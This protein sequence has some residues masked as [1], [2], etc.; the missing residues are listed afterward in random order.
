MSTI[1]SV[2]SVSVSSTVSE[3]STATESSTTS[4]PSIPEISETSI[5]SE[6]SEAST[7]FES[8]TSSETSSETT[9]VVAPSSIPV[10]SSSSTYSRSSTSAAGSSAP[11]SASEPSSF[12]SS[13]SPSSSIPVSISALTS[14]SV[15]GTTLSEKSFISAT[16][17]VVSIVGLSETL[18]S[19]AESEALTE[20]S[21]SFSAASISAEPSISQPIVTFISINS[22][23]SD[24]PTP[25]TAVSQDTLY[26][27]SSTWTASESASSFVV[28]R[29]SSI[30]SESETTPPLSAESSR[31]LSAISGISVSQNTVS[32]H[33][34]GTS[35]LVESTPVSGFTISGTKARESS[36]GTS[37]VSSLSRSSFLLTSVSGTTFTSGGPSSPTSEPTNSDK[38]PHVAQT[39]ETSIGTATSGPG[40]S[41]ASP[42]PT[43]KASD[44][45]TSVTWP[46]WKL[47]ESL[48]GNFAPLVVARG[49]M[50]MTGAF[51]NQA[52]THDPVR[53]LTGGGISGSAL[54]GP[55]IGASHIGLVTA[56][57]G[58]IFVAGGTFIDTNYCND[59]A[60]PNSINPCPPKVSGNPWVLD[61]I[62][63]TLV[64]QAGVVAYT[65]SKWFQKP[66]RLSADPTTIAGVAA[67]MG[68]PEIER[69]FAAFSGEMS[70]WELQLAL[71]GQQFKLG[72]FETD[73]GVTKYGI[74][75]VPLTEQK[76]GGVFGGIKESFQHLQDRISFFFGD[77]KLNRLVLDVAFGL[78]LLTLLGLTL[79][80][81]A[82]VDRPQTVFLATATG[83]GVGMKIF[84]AFLGVIISSN[85]GRLFEDTQTFTPYFP[86]RDGEARPNPTILL[87]RHTSPICAFI[88]LLRNR[89]LAAASVAFTGLISEFLII[90][91]AGLPYRPGQ[92]RTEFLFCGVAS[93]VILSV[94]LAQLVLVVIWRRSL[95]HLPR[96]PDTIAA[97][98][99]YVA[100][101]SMARD[102]YGLEEMSTKER[103]RAI[104]EMR[105]VYAYGWR[106]EP[107]GGIRWIVDEVPDAEKKSFLESS[108]VG[109]SGIDTS[110]HGYYRPNVI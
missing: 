106:Q 49:L 43:P 6:G 10:H 22:A 89:H 1:A 5:V 78:L 70:K 88:P 19:S 62:I 68:H 100:G 80:A 28:V 63:T 107:E 75:P 86:L 34:T 74:M 3:T 16:T 51:Y 54:A 36:A 94:M 52:L 29:F 66:G 101:T 31:S 108:R 37:A 65:M 11:L 60:N 87:N 15:S 72:T 13:V 44:P 85:W 24:R 96:R 8:L 77:W 32:I 103:N 76:K 50:L 64:I 47:T 30:L 25:Q 98:M 84:F 95:P 20:Y 97:V 61:I 9:T 2:S 93:A 67:V 46:Y 53:K 82:H 45:L 56:Q 109:L 14:T 17:S 48:T 91:L 92:L 81:I 83:S 7:T 33:S 26:S 12:T 55:H 90:T 27:L 69:Q 39:A 59:P 18:S 40:G 104:C 4:E 110:Y 71:Q 73:T 57:V 23:T 58:T 38:P 79:A 35:G 21:F 102:F 99:T 105:K 42:S 41:T